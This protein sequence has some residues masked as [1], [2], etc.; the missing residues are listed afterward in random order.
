MSEQRIVSN[1]EEIGETNV[2]D[3]VYFSLKKCRHRR[4]KKHYWKI[5]YQPPF[6]NIKSS[7]TIAHIIF[8]TFH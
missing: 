4:N 6:D 5:R 3:S 7:S 8:F 2:I 1:P